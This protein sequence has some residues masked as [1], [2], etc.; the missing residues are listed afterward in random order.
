VVTNSDQ[1]TPLIVTT[2]PANCYHT[3]NQLLPPYPQNVTTLPANCYPKVPVLDPP[4]T[5]LFILEQGGTSADASENKNNTANAFLEPN[6]QQPVF[7]TPHP[8]ANTAPSAKPQKPI[9]FNSTARALVESI[10]LIRKTEFYDFNL[11]HSIVE[12]VTEA[13]RCRPA[14]FTRAWEELT[15]WEG[16]TAYLDLVNASAGVIGA[17]VIEWVRDKETIKSEYTTPQKKGAPVFGLSYMRD[18][19]TEEQW[20]ERIC[21]NEGKQQ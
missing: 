8:A 12:E 15:A 6:S 4:L 11:A 3:G 17:K 19:E 14:A 10:K 16:F 18:D 2:P 9:S 13:T 1:Y 21:N 7:S 20:L 5:P